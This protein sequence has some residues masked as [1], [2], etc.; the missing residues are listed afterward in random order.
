MSSGSSESSSS[1]STSTTT[2]QYDQRVGAEAGAVA[3]GQGA[4]LSYNEQFPENVSKAF[5]EL[6]NLARDAGKLII[7][8]NENLQEATKRSLESNEKTL[9]MALEKI[10]AQGAISADVSKK[11]TEKLAGLLETQGKGAST[12][13]EKI[14]GLLETQGKGASTIYTDIFPYIAAGIIGLVAILIFYKS[15]AR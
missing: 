11:T 6:I 1:T 15:K 8:S 7:N 10:S 3:L 9:Q 14:A 5:N 2:N 13:T 12:I 4:S